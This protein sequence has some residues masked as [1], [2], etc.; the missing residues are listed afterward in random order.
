MA[1]VK[2]AFT[3]D[4]HLPI[5]KAERIASLVSEAAAFGPDALVVAGDLA[6]NP[7]ELVHCLRIVREAAG[8]PVW[9]LAGNHDLWAHPP[10][11]SHRLWRERLPE[12]VAEADCRWLEGT[13]FVVGDTAVAGTIGWY[14]Y[15]AVDPSIQAT[16]LEFA[17]KKMHY[18]ADALRIDWGWSDPEFAERVGKP[19]LA[20]LDGL[21]ANPAV[22]RIV[23]AT[24]V[25]ILEEQM[26]RDSSN[27]DWA[28]S[29]AYFGNLTLGRRVLERS[30]VSHVISGHTHVGRQARVERSAAESVEAVVLASDYE[31]PVWL[32]LTFNGD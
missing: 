7:R 12:A 24:H 1:A 17:Q 25:P 19:F 9:V 21:E 11:D 32:G 20:T 15:S 23:V 6:E 18:N 2:V 26:C 4:L 14:D 13:A 31:K 8:C 3:S 10:Y 5:T 29:N 30:K 27:P 28:F 22:R 16:A